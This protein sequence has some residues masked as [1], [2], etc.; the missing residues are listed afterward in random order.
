MEAKCLPMA[1]QSLYQLMTNPVVTNPAVTAD[2]VVQKK[3][4][5]LLMKTVVAE[6]LPQLNL[7]NQSL[8]LMKATALMSLSLLITQL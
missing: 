5:S 6:K 7:L 8:F 3:Y 4:L 2:Q 1:E